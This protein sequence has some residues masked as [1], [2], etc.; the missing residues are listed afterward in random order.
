MECKGQAYLKENNAEFQLV[1]MQT[2]L[3]LIVI[4]IISKSKSVRILKS[5]L[6]CD[7]TL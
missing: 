2:D 5:S 6:F 1:K 4:I 7:I 3:I